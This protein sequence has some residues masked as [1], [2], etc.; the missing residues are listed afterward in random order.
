MTQA[1]FDAWLAG[2][3]G[4]RAGWIAAFVRPALAL[5]ADPHGGSGF[6]RVL[7]RAFECVGRRPTVV[8]TQV[9]HVMLA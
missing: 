9:G 4:C 7:A 1:I 3:D 2:I 6:V 8:E 5:S